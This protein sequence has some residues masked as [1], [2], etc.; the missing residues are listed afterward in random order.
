MIALI[1]MAGSGKST[2]RQLLV[3]QL[4]CAWIYPGQLLRDNLSGQERANMLAGKHINDDITIRLLEADFIKK[5]VK[6]QECVLDGAPRS[7]RQAE[8]FTDLVN[9]GEVKL[10]GI[11]H[12]AMDLN[13]AKARLLSR[14]R[15]DDSLQ[16]ITE[17][18][19]V[20]QTLTRPVF[21]YLTSHGIAVSEVSAGGTPQEVNSRIRQALKLPLTEA[22]R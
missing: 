22:V 5:D 16:A 19:N 11:I 7:L 15:P 2:Q 17:R 3:D 13:E 20:F 14:E 6:R 12:L 4:H 9:R 1:G 21:E 10:T 18:F 8:W